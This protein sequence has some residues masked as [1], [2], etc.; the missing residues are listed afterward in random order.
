MPFRVLTLSLSAGAVPRDPGFPKIGTG[1][2]RHITGFPKN[3]TEYHRI[4]GRTF[5]FPVER[6][7]FGRAKMEFARIHIKKIQNSE[8]NTS[9][10]SLLMLS[11]APMA[12]NFRD[13][14][15]FKYGEWFLSEV[16]PQSK[17]R[18]SVSFPNAKEI[19]NVLF[20][21]SRM[22]AKSA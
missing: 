12:S 9:L 13:E 17:F 15:L 4:S 7:N 11:L 3:I 16:I 18:R 10:F 21:I 20:L 5:E 2:P 6:S 8:M 14:S 22:S 1:F 19:Q